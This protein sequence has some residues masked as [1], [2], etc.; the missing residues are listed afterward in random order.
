M[1]RACGVAKWFQPAYRQL[2]ERFESLSLG[3]AEKLGL[4]QFVVICRIRD[5]LSRFRLEDVV[6]AVDAR[7]D[8]EEVTLHGRCGNA[9]CRMKV[10]VSG[11]PYGREDLCRGELEKGGVDAAT[12]VADLVADAEELRVAVEEGM[13]HPE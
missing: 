12:R 7:L 6:R 13:P 9:D 2:C 1:A 10:K 8:Y 11:K 4:P 5:K 3:E